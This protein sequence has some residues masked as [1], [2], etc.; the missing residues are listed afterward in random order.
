[1]RSTFDAFRKNVNSQNGE[2]GILEELVN[3]LGIRGAGSCM[4]FGAGNGVMLS[5]TLELTKKGWRTVLCEQNAA[6]AQSCRELAAT[7]P[8]G[9]V[10]V[11]EGTVGFTPEDG[12]DAVL[13]DHAPDMPECFDVLSIDVDSYDLQIWRA[14]EKYR[15]KVVIIEINSAIPLGVAQEHVGGEGGAQGASFSSMLDLA[16]DK[17]YTLVCHTGNLV[18]VDTNYITMLRLPLSE[19]QNPNGLFDPSW[20]NSAV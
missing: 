12:V 18:F 17:R 7:F 9:Q 4:E 5:N 3:R 2:D 20:A 15:P 10:T 19:I 14:I 16:F 8:H 6:S 1:M 13:Q 11:V